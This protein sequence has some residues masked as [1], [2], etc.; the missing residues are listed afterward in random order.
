MAKGLNVPANQMKKGIVMWDARDCQT[1]Y[2]VLD[3]KSE[4]TLTTARGVRATLTLKKAKGH[5]ILTIME[6]K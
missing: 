6:D 5:N 4:F 1:C 2:A 3:L